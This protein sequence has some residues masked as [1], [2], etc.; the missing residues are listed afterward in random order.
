[1]TTMATSWKAVGKSGISTYSEETDMPKATLENIEAMYQVIVE[2]EDFI[3]EE[4][5][6]TDIY[7][8]MKH[9]D[10]HIAACWASRVGPVASADWRIV[11]DDEKQAEKLT[12]QIKCFPEWQ[13]YNVALLDAVFRGFAGVEWELNPP[14]ADCVVKNVIQINQDNIVFK[15]RGEPRLRTLRRPYEGEPMPFP[16]FHVISWGERYHGRRRGKGVAQ[17]LFWAWFFK[18]KGYKFWGNALE[19][20]GMPGLLMKIKGG[21]YAQKKTKGKKIMRDYVGG[22]GVVVS[23]EDD[24][25]VLTPSMRIG[26]SNKEFEDFFNAEISKRT[27]GQTLTTEQGS[28]GSQALGKVHGAV[29]RDILHGDATWLADIHTKQTLAGMGFYLFGDKYKRAKFEF[30]FED[31][32]LAKADREG[33]RALKEVKLPMRTEDV[34]KLAHV[35][36]PEDGEDVFEW[37]MAPAPLFG[38]PEAG[39]K[40]PNAPPFG[41]EK[42]AVPPTKGGG[43]G[44]GKPEPPPEQDD[45]FAEQGGTAARERRHKRDLQQ[46]DDLELASMVKAVTDFRKKNGGFDQFKRRASKKV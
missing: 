1:M 38:S 15:P 11:S 45:Q 43:P 18:H 13:Q 19:R 40:P 42:Q 30:I 32:E 39:G 36:E 29:R 21:D 8:R 16:Q 27:L 22:A 4:S 23:D 10:A 28:K 3:L 9:R 41:K 37:P 12:E 35:P 25:T 6:R 26:A 33:L 24:V 34:Y 20:F 31:P 5:K 7:D 46:T 17:G 2:D 44:K 14:D